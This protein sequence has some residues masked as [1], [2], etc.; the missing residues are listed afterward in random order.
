[1]AETPWAGMTPTR[2]AEAERASKLR[3]RSTETLTWLSSE[4]P[5]WSCGTPVSEPN[6]A[7]LIEVNSR[8]LAENAYRFPLAD[9]YDRRSASLQASA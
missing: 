3:A 7:R 5:H 2:M 9:E 1:M 8:W 4:K 6:R